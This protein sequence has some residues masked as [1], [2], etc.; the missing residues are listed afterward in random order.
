MQRVL[1]CLSFPSEGQSRGLGLV[2]PTC[3]ALNTGVVNVCFQFGVRFEQIA[4]TAKV[5][6]FLATSFLLCSLG[7][8]QIPGKD[9]LRSMGLTVFWYWPFKLL[10]CP[11]WLLLGLIWSHPPSSLSHSTIL[12]VLAHTG[13]SQSLEG[14]HKMK[15]ICIMVSELI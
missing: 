5:N 6:H 4:G 12:V 9:F 14:L 11:Y 8:C 2:W 10:Q 3:L 13:L 15:N 1:N 7:F